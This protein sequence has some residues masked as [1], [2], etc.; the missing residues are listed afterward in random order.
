MYE[1]YTC[2]YKSTSTNNWDLTSTSSSE[3]IKAQ[4]G[5]SVSPYVS[6][7][8]CTNCDLPFGPRGPRHNSWRGRASQRPGRWRLNWCWWCCASWWCL[9]PACIWTGCTAQR[10]QQDPRT[11]WCCRCW[12]RRWQRTE[13]EAELWRRRRFEKFHV[14]EMFWGLE[15]GLFISQ[16]EA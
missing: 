3:R 16:E 2:Y 6:S 13:E 7:G 11:Q 14:L 15:N 1:I 4:R 5:V 8:W 10:K 12:G 9:S